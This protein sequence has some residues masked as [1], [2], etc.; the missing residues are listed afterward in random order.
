M[1]VTC[2]SHACHMHVTCMSQVQHMYVA[3]TTHVRTSACMGTTQSC[4]CMYITYHMYVAGTTHVRTSA[5]MGTTQ[6]CVCMYIT[7]PQGRSCYGV[8]PVCPLVS[9]TQCLLLNTQCSQ[10][11]LSTTFEHFL[12]F[13]PYNL[14]SSLIN[15][16][17]IMSCQ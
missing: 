17:F 11:T 2:M 12:C 15:G 10:I 7:Y 16:I 13:L 6:S 1:H 14:F 4:V 9:K 3:G 8:S 5:C